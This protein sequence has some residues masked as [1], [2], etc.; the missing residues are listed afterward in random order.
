MVVYDI[1]K[2][3]SLQLI[4]SINFFLTKHNLVTGKANSYAL[5]L[6]WYYTKQGYAYLNKS[7]VKHLYIKQTFSEGLNK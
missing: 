3:V 5:A 1:C 4:K 7:N 2:Y 6:I